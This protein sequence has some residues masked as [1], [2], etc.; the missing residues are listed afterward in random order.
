VKS[1]Y[2]LLVTD[3]GTT[4]YSAT[5]REANRVRQQ[6]IDVITI[7]IGDSLDTQLLT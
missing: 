6:G 4:D 5:R 3:G 2:L 1:R 7:A